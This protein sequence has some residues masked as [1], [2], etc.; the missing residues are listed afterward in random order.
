VSR[1]TNA[2][3]EATH[4]Y[5]DGRMLYR[6]FGLS[7]DL[8]KKGSNLTVTVPDGFVTDGPS[9]PDWAWPFIPTE[10]MVKSAALH[11]YMRERLFYS[12]SLGD[13]VFYEALKVECK[14]RWLCRL[15]YLAVALNKSRARATE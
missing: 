8:G 1:F 3:F 4:L 6:V 13:A 2:T 11:D 9:V 14:H 15:A 7:F 10:L 5:R 12:K